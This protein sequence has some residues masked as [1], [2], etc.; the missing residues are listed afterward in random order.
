LIN[1]DVHAGR[2]TRFVA[3]RRMLLVRRTGACGDQQQHPRRGWWSWA[4][5][6]PRSISDNS[7]RPV[8]LSGMILTPLPLRSERRLA[9]RGPIDVDSGV[10]GASEAYYARMLALY[11]DGSPRL[12]SDYPEPER[13]PGE[14][15]LRMRLAGICDTDLQLTRGYMQ[16]RGVLGHEVVAEVIDADAPDLVGQRVVVDIN[17]NCGIC[18]HCLEDDGHHCEARSVLGIA[19]RDGALAERFTMPNHCLV[20][21]PDLVSDERAVFA[22]PLAAALH[23]LDEID[24]ECVD[25][26]IVIGDGKLG[27]LVGLILAQTRMQVTQIGHHPE[28][29]ELLAPSGVA[30][31]LEAE[32]FTRVDRAPLVVEASGS[33][34]GLELALRLVKPRGKVVLKTTV[35]DKTTVPLASLVIDEVALVGSRCGDV[36][37]AIDWLAHHTIDPTRLIAARYPLA[38]AEEAL[39]HAGMKNVL[40]VL[41]SAN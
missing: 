6:L 19:R 31:M 10:P 35:A 4:H 33:N 23:V 20:A 41:V 2:A 36:R 3:E 12:V 29:L 37:V 1:L 18:A 30:T 40:K 13:R 24:V 25:R 21:V 34:S 7:S 28:K 17:A 32:A 26:A 14:A 8:E 22:E 5:G 16:Y 11:L 38:R 15:L 27:L 9:D 39:Q